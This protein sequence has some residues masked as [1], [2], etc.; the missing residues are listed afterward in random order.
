MKG[1]GGTADLTVNELAVRYWEHAEKHYRKP[2]GSLTSE[3]TCLK[4]ALRPLKQLYGHTLA[5]DFGPVE[6]RTV[7][8]RMVALGWV[9]RSIN[10]HLSRL[11]HLFR[12][13]GEQGWVK[14]DVYNGL[15]CVSGLRAGRSEAKESEPVRPVRDA[16]VDTVLPF[17]TP[18][19]AAM[20]P[21]QRLTGM[22]PGEVC[23]MRVCELDTSGQVW[24]YRPDSHKTQHHG[25]ERAI[26]IGPKAQAFIRP[27]LTLDTQAYLFSPAVSEA[28]RNAER[29]CPKS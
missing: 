20:V 23:R 18:Q 10:L 24:V 21:L 22:R 27:F 9:R 1:A 8:D 15:L 16:F 4:I 17:L 25:H 13:A 19:V 28:G 3:T 2:D 12:W 5:N 14:P 26:Y 29:R 11:K 6:L 7:R